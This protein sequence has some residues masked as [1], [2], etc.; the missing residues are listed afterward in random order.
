MTGLRDAHSAPFALF[1]FPGDVPGF[2]AF[3]L[4][5]FVS[6]AYSGGISCQQ[7]FG[8]HMRNALPYSQ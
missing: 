1:W 6:S 7:L 8:D 4:F 5:V 3:F 2:S